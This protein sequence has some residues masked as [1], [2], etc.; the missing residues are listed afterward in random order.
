MKHILLDETCQDSGT[1]GTSTT[2][3][4]LFKKYFMQ[5]YKAISWF[6]AASMTLA[7]VA[8]ECQ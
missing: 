6:P 3:K 5:T 1:A 2:E 7:V 8:R 4:K